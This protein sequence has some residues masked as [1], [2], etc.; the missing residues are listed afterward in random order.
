N[1]LNINEGVGATSMRSTVEAVLEHKADLGFALD[2]DGDRIMM[3]DHLGNVIDGDQVLF[4]IARD[5]L[6]GGR[7]NGG[8]VVG[9][10]MSN[11]GLEI[12]LNKLGVPF[13]RSKVGDR[14]V[15]ELLQQKNWTI[16]GENSGHVL[17]LNLASTGDGIIAGLQVIS[18]MLRANMTLHD[19]ASGFEKFPQTLVNVRFENADS[20]PLNSDEVLT[21]KAE[22]ESALGKQGRVLLRKSGTEPLIRVMVE[23]DDELASTTWAEKIADAVRNVSS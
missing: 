9:T 14:Y 21:A 11:L 16:G 13:V 23:S 4:I 19:L 8:G 5:A 6:K 18:A 3:V 22:A 15:M 2:G 1:G 12:A 10:L 17:N 20:D 7:L